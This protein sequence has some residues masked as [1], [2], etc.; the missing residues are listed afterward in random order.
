MVHLSALTEQSYIK[1]I[2]HPKKK[3][4]S[5]VRVSKWWY[6]FK[7]THI[8]STCTQYLQSAATWL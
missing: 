5:S 3:H 1:G 4:L 8:N 7:T 2:V 6:P